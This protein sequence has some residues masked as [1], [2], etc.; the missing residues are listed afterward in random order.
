MT[1]T[2]HDERWASSMD[3]ET[4]LLRNR[5]AEQ[6]RTVDELS[7]FEDSRASVRADGAAPTAHPRGLRRRAPAGDGRHPFQDV[8][9]WAGEVRT[10]G[11]Q[12]EGR[13]FLPP[14][15]AG[16]IIDGAAC[17]IRED[18]MLAPGMGNARWS[19]LLA[20]RFNDVNDAHPFHDCNGRTQRTYF[21]QVAKAGDKT[22]DWSVLTEEQNIAVSHA[23][24]SG[25]LEPLRSALSVRV[26]NRMDPLARQ[27][28]KQAAE[29]ICPAPTGYAAGRSAGAGERSFYGPSGRASGQNVTGPRCDGYDR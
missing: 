5:S 24:R 1:G 22:I 23:A 18:G 4:G 25:N 13:R 12:K 29:A 2:D 15:L 27:R 14:G 3:H 8:Y 16:I 19:D 20:D 6:I 11:I 10:V 26:T 9:P 7:A 21:N 17:M 28:A